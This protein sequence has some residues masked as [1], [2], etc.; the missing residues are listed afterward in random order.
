MGQSRPFTEKKTL[1]AEDA[2]REQYKGIGITALAA[3]HYASAMKKEAR[4][5]K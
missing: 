3:A 4:A 1:E 5:S 2:L